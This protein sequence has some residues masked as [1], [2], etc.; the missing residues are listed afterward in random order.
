MVIIIHH[1]LIIYICN[2]KLSINPV[3]PVNPA[4][5]NYAATSRR[6]KITPLFGY[7]A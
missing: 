3:D 4:L 7:G 6:P 1:S 2:T 5:N